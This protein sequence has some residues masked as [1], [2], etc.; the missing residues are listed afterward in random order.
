MYVVVTTS[1]IIV[2]V[3]LRTV[4]VDMCGYVG[5]GESVGVCRCGCVD[6]THLSSH[7]PII[8]NKE[9]VSDFSVGHY[10]GRLACMVVYV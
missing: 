9:V 1:V 6:T 2:H 4:C 5:V 3:F 8:I 10:H 7:I